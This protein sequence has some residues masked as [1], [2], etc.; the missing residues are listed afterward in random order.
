M[1]QL[2]DARGESITGVLQALVEGSRHRSA[3]AR[4]R[5]YPQ[6][7]SIL[8][9]IEVELE[10]VAAAISEEFDILAGPHRPGQELRSSRLNKAFAAFEEK[11]SEVG[12]Q[13]A[14]SGTP[15]QTNMEYYLAVLLDHPR[16]LSG[17]PF[18]G[19]LC[20]G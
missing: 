12:D 18:A 3:V 8:S 2:L 17:L 1:A 9:R 20:S 14:L 6:E 5:K 4:T 13:G 10:E 19:S 15:L 16:L 11:V 7:T